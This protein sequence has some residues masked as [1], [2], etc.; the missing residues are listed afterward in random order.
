MAVIEDGFPQLIALEGKATNL[1]SAIFYP[2]DMGEEILI[3][4]AAV[5]AYLDQE[6]GRLLRSLKSILGSALID[7]HTDLGPGRV[8]SFSD[9][10]SDY[11]ARLK[12]RAEKAIGHSLKRVLLGRPAFFVDDDPVRDQQAQDSLESAA[13]RAGFDEI[14]FEFEPVAAAYTFASDPEHAR[15]NLS[16]QRWALVA[17]LGGGTCDFSLLSLESGEQRILANHGVHVAGTDFDR[18]VAL[19]QIMPLL[20]LGALNPNGRAV[21]NSIYRDL[22]TWH[23]VNGLY[24]RKSKAELHTHR[25]L[26]G[27]KLFH[28]RLTK[29]LD[30][31][32]GHQ[33]LAQA[34]EAKI[35]ASKSGQFD[36]LFDDLERGLKHSVSAAQVQLAITDELSKIA[37]A[38][39]ATLSQAGIAPSQVTELFFTGGSSGLEILRANIASKLP[40]ARLIEGERFE[41]VTLG[42]G[43]AATQRWAEQ[44]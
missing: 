17:D 4:R 44:T 2:S 36:M 10:I 31:R 7:A 26:Y 3:G 19:T 29:V 32:L 43:L 39:L 30:E 13:R 20:G 8:M 41:S 12:S 40:Q 21:P 33:L 25:D 16:E 42:L 9:I 5:A 6:D 18:R 23:L 38:A 27:G 11:L 35:E 1:P 34:E 22:S 28:T 37:E 14:S 24:S 15:P